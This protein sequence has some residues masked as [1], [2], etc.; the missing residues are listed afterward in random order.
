MERFNPNLHKCIGGL[1]VYFDHNDVIYQNLS[2]YKKV[3]IYGEGKKCRGN[4]KTNFPYS[5]I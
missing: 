3:V 5:K 2:M 1:L 4:V